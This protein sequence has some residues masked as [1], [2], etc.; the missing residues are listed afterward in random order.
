MGEL[1]IFFFHF[2]VKITESLIHI[3]AQALGLLLHS[4]QF[5]GQFGRSEEGS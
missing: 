4:V 3:P 1:G 2:P 5:G